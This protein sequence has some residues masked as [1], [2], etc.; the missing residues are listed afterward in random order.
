MPDVFNTAVP[1]HSVPAF[2]GSNTGPATVPD[3]AEACPSDPTLFTRGC[4]VLLQE[5]STNQIRENS[6][7]RQNEPCKLR[8]KA[9]VIKGKRLLALG[10]DVVDI[11]RLLPR[12]IER[13]YAKRIPMLPG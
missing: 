9:T 11:G 12:R 3:D 4:A 5:V 10:Q 1:D 8:P 6:N 2:P 7:E 13:K